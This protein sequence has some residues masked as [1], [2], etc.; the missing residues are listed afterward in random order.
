MFTTAPFITPK[1]QK[2]PKCSSAMEWIEWFA[3][4]MEFYT[5][6]TKNKLLLRAAE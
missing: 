2:L 5:A 1:N 6:L 3:Y 4:T